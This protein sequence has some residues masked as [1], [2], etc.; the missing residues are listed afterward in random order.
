VNNRYLYV[1]D[2]IVKLNI[3]TKFEFELL[4]R[5]VT[6]CIFYKCIPKK[7]IDS[8]RRHYKKK[9]YIVRIQNKR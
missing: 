7:R 9:C 6:L 3:H 8:K 5:L 2:L 1:E 4:L